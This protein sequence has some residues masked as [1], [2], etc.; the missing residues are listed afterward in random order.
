M[1]KI[2]AVALFLASLAF[3]HNMRAEVKSFQIE[4][5]KTYHGMILE[6]VADPATTSNSMWLI[7]LD[8]GN[9]LRVRL[10]HGVPSGQSVTLTFRDAQ[11]GFFGGHTETVCDV[12]LDPVTTQGNEKEKASIPVYRSGEYYK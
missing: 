1:K 4:K 11:V 10:V 9:L 8:D 7:R 2:L 12:Q 5:G 6:S 3:T